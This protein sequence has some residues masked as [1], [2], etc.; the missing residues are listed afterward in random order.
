MTLAFD[1]T[2]TGKKDILAAIHERDMTLRPQLVKKKINPFYHSLIK[3]FKSLTGVA[4]LLNT[5]LNFH[6]KPIVL[7]PQDLLKEV[8]MNKAV[9]LNCVLIEDTLFQRK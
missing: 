1:S 9:E 5:S 3:E 2:E 7:K 6:G 4:A 8:I